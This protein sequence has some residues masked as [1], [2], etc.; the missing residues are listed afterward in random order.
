VGR[1]R[2]GQVLLYKVSNKISE[3]AILKQNFMW[4]LFKLFSNKNLPIKQK[5]SSV[6]NEVMKKY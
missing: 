3:N 1:V 2:C 4:Q 6:E 5:N